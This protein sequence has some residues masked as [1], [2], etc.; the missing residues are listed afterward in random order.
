MGERR[1]AGSEG[2]GAGPV[3]AVHLWVGIAVLA[4]NTA[5]AAV[6]GAAWFRSVPSVA[7]WYVLRVAQATVVVQAAI[8]LALF[9]SGRRAED[10]L[11]I[12]YGIAPLVVAL[13]SEAMRVGAAQRELEGVDDVESLERTE[14]VRLARRVVLRET[15]IMAVGCLLIVT[16][17]L[18][19]AT[20]GG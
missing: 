2:A 5:A 6:G 7:F 20:T 4:T 15:A 19:A 13:V 18:R 3:N 8:G 11:H 12:A 1:R 17:A 10:D 16:L 14:Q 9:A